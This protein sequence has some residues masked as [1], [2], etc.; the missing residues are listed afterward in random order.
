MT[1]ASLCARRGGKWKRSTRTRK[2]AKSDTHFCC[3]RCRK[4]ISSEVVEKSF[5]PHKSCFASLSHHSSA[6]R[7]EWENHF[8]HFFFPEKHSNLNI[9]WGGRKFFLFF[10]CQNEKKRFAFWTFLFLS[11]ICAPLSPH[12]SQTEPNLKC[13]C[14]AWKFSALISFRWKQIWFLVFV[15]LFTLCK[16]FERGRKGDWSFCRV[17]WFTF[18]EKLFKLEWIWKYKLK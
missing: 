4:K 1:F 2:Q 10:C 17:F 16:C 8:S 3:F 12:F 6:I 14:K 13:F 5:A 18:R 7:A 9:C 11:H 15:A